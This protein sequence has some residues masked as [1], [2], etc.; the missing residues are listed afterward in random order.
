MRVLAILPVYNEE[1]TIYGVLKT[2]TSSQLLD[3]IVVIDK[4]TDNSLEKIKR[5]EHIELI[6]DH[7]D[8]RGKGQAVRI[9]T[10]NI[11]EDIVFLCDADLVGFRKEHIE[12]I[13]NPLLNGEADMCV[14]LRDRFGPIGRFLARY[15]PLIGGERAIYTKH[16]KKIREIDLIDDYGLEIVMNEYCK[17]R[18]LKIKKINLRGYD[19]VFKYHKWKHIPFRTWFQ[20]WKSGPP[21]LFI[22]WLKVKRTYF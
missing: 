7:P 16:F 5:F 4:S 22:T 3:R 11:E 2:L 19:Q 6:H 15:T 10:E 21:T 14:G 9:A 20:K 17:R 18:G 8:D 12:K 1:K 13:L